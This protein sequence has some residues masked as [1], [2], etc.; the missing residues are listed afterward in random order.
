MQ[1]ESEFNIKFA[2]MKGFMTRFLD[3]HQRRLRA[4]AILALDTWQEQN[5]AETRKRLPNCIKRACFELLLRSFRNLEL[6]GL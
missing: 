3:L 1:L 2:T 5:T 4:R 6:V